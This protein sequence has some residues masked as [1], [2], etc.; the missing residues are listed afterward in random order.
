MKKFQTSDLM[1][2][3]KP[4]EKKEANTP[5]GS[6]WHEIIKL[7]AE[8]NK[9]EAKITIE[10]NVTKSFFKKNQQDGQTFIQTN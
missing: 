6:R 4:L 5:K 2:H 8:V 1:A 9:I 10:I 3:L 7:Q